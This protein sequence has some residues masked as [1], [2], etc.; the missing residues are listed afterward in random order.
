MRRTYL[1]IL[2]TVLISGCAVTPSQTAELQKYLGDQC[3]ELI[4]MPG[5]ANYKYHATHF[6][7]GVHAY[8]A[9]ASDGKDRQ[10]CSFSTISEGLGLDNHNKIVAISRCENLRA[11]YGI[12]SPCKIFARNYQIVY[13]KT[14]S[15]SME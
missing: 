15:F 4:T 9:L 10:V 11:S 13:D 14:S 2:F 6:F 12:Q 1:S 5:V 8:F 3:Y 7:P